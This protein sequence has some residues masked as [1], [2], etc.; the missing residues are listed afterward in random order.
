M[1]D[2]TGMG[3]EWRTRAGNGG[4]ET[5]G[6]DG[7]ETGSL[8]KRKEGK[9]NSTTSIGA[10]LTPDFRDKEESSNNIVSV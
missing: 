9:H 10:S 1:R 6:G 4:V 8:T 7:S 2:L 3:G 5:G